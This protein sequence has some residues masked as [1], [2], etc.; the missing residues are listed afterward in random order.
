MTSWPHNE[1]LLLKTKTLKLQFLIFILLALK[2][3]KGCKFWCHIVGIK[4]NGNKICFLWH[5]AW[6]RNDLL[7]LKSKIQLAHQYLFIASNTHNHVAQQGHGQRKNW[8]FGHQIVKKS[9]LWLIFE[10][11]SKVFSSLYYATFLLE[12]NNTFAHQD[13]KVA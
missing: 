11:L 13:T 12:N 1:L 5:P 3:V 9:L 4:M 8:S 7:L 10:S 6:P 2:N